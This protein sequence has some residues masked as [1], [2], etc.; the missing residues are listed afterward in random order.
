MIS[1]GQN[2]P[3]FIDEA[4]EAQREYMAWPKATQQVSERADTEAMPDV[5]L[6]PQPS[7][8]L[9]RGEQLTNSPPIV[10]EKEKKTSRTSSCHLLGSTQHNS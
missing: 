3:H 7:W 10:R 2:C 8:V 6:L 5:K 9:L 1:K 4:F